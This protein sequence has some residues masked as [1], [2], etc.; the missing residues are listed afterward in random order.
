MLYLEKSDKKQNLV[1]F[2]QLAY[3]M[4]ANFLTIFQRDGCLLTR[5]KKTISRRGGHSDSFAPITEQGDSYA[6]LIKLNF[7]P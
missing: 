7:G 2:K 6:V 4:L 3:Y 5:Q 1:S